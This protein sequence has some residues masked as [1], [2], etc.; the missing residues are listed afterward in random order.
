MSRHVV[1]VSFPVSGMKLTKNNLGDPG[2]YSAHD[3]TPLS[4]ETRAGSQE[5]NLREE[6]RQH[7]GALY[8]GLPPV[9]PQIS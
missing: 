5:I 8:G 2:I 9:I 4:R 6:M 3:Y 1:I 7:G